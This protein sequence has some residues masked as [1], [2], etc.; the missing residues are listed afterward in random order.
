MP[1]FLIERLK[2]EYGAKSHIPYAVANSIGAMKGNKETPK[3][4]AMERKH[5]R[6]MGHRARKRG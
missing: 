4:A 1:K 2:R 6:D 3:G 5:N